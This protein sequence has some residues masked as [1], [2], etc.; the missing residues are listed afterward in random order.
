MIVRIHWPRHWVT[1]LVPQIL[2][3]KAQLKAGVCTKSQWI[4]IFFNMFIDTVTPFKWPLVWSFLVTGILYLKTWM[5]EVESFLTKKSRLKF[6]LVVSN[7]SNYTLTLSKYN[8]KHI[9][10]TPS[11]ATTCNNNWL[12]R[13]RYNTYRLPLESEMNI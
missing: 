12:T 11:C 4:Y 9:K 8:K 13:L 10:H 2:I 3:F 1:R 6:N 5:T 7:D